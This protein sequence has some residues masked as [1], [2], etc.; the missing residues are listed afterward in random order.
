[1]VDLVGAALG[2]DGLNEPG[3]SQRVA[4]S[5]ELLVDAFEARRRQREM[6]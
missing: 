5:V 2:D 6:P 4:D 1:V 3:C